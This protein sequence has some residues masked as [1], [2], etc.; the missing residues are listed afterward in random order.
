MST[1]RSQPR[2]AMEAIDVENPQDVTFWAVLLDASADEVHQAL[3]FAGPGL[4][5]ISQYIRARR[6]REIVS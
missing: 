6:D 4:F 2:A 3:R 5:E 1:E